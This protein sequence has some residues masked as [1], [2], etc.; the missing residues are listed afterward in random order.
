MISYITDKQEITKKILSVLDYVDIN[1]FD[2][3]MKTWWVNIRN[4]GGLSLTTVG[5]HMFTLANIDYHDISTD[6]SYINGNIKY[7]LMLDR[8]MPCPYYLHHINK[9]IFVRIYDSRVVLLITLQG[10][11]ERFLKNKSN[12]HN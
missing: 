4:N 5:D 10:G 6:K 9:K 7:L 1:D 3:A 12:I 8:K 2:T 11:I